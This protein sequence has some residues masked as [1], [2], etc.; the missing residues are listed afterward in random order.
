MEKHTKINH[1]FGYF[2][3]PEK[4]LPIANQNDESF[5]VLKLG[6]ILENY[7]STYIINV[8]EIGTEE[9]IKDSR[10]FAPKLETCVA[11]GLPVSIADAFKTF[12]NIRNKFAHRLEYQMTDVD[13]D[14]LKDKV[15]AISK[16]DANFNN[17]FNEKIN[18]LFD[19]G[20]D[21]VALLHN[22]PVNIDPKKHRVI[23]LTA[24]AYALSNKGA[25]FIINKLD[26]LNKL[27]IS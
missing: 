24:I 9:Y 26:S 1:D 17:Y 14:E 3:N 6:L 5:A 25:F 4:Y 20:V 12:N 11:L 10:Y 16:D 13:I 22:L 7:L 18:T 27:D 2:L 15:N 8:R 23:K 19:V 21:S